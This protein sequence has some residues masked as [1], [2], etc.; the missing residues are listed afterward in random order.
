MVGRSEIYMTEA[1]GLQTSVSTCAATKHESQR[2][3]GQDEQPVSSH[4]VQV[5]DSPIWIWSTAV[6]AWSEKMHSYCLVSV[7]GSTMWGQE[8]FL[9]RAWVN[10][11]PLVYIVICKIYNG[12]VFGV[13]F[14]FRKKV[15][16]WKAELLGLCE[17]GENSRVNKTNREQQSRGRE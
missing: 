4:R 1:W 15:S 9:F 8:Y 14:S 6:K 7:L 16:F 5:Q 2:A 3:G 11:L 17:L 12:N 10:F 13:W